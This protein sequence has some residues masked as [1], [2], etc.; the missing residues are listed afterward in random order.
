MPD[1]GAHRFGVIDQLRVEEWRAL[2]V[3]PAEFVREIAANGPTGFALGTELAAFRPLDG[4]SEAVV[5]IDKT[6]LPSAAE[7][8]TSP[9]GEEA[10][11]KRPLSEA[12]VFGSDAPNRLRFSRADL[13]GSDESNR[14]EIVRL[15]QV[16]GGV[17]QLTGASGAEEVTFD[18]TSS[19]P[20]DD[21]LS[22]FQFHVIEPDGSES[23]GI[24][25]VDALPSD[26]LF[27]NQWHHG[28]LNVTDV[29]DDYTG[30][31][32]TVGFNDHG[33]EYTHPDLNDNYNT[34]IDYDYTNNDSNPYPPS[35]ESHGTAV[36]GMVGAERNGTGVVGIAYD[37]TLA[38]YRGFGVRYN[39]GRESHADIINNSWGPAGWASFFYYRFVRGGDRSYESE[40]ETAVT[41]GRG[42]LGQIITFSAGNDRGIDARPEYSNFSGHRH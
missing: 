20:A 38:S 11:S 34:S 41:N 9:V 33:I 27:G 28:Q 30:Q 12:S 1:G 18:L 25:E 3:P 4:L 40:I 22:M 29:W 13:L 35:W 8:A 2:S 14:G 23:G 17:A 42:G 24:V 37:A 10:G 31:G 5:D 39:V 6:P 21:D 15:S 19:E 32:V 7:I 26:S 36:A 16:R